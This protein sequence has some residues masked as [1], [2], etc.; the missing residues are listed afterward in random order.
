MTPSP[1]LATANLA[2]LEP[3]SHLCAFYDTD[4]QLARIASTFVAWGLAAGDQML[5]VAGDGDAA[6][7]MLTSL[8]DHLPGS[9]ALASGQLMVRTFEDT[10]GG[11]H[12]GY[13]VRI[14]AGFRAAA[15]ES[16][17]SGYPALRVAAEMGDVATFLGSSDEVLRW[18]RRATAMQRDLGVSS[19]CQYDL[20]HIEKGHAASLAAEHTALA[21]DGDESPMATFLAVGDPWGLRVA[22][23]VDIANRAGLIRAIRSRAAVS[24]RVHL[25]LHGLTFADVGTL[26][27]LHALAAA[28]PHDG[29]LV[30]RR[31][32]DLLRRILDI[33]GLRHQRLVVEA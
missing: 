5:Y 12:D 9:H 2:D 32:P 24:P 16:R 22:G 23:E 26:S 7:T 6:T 33:T 19:V 11:T 30:L 10:Y 3:G 17:K 1:E 28:L 4:Q 8:L 27:G 20:R 31:P 29:H 18:E 13:L 15:E 21:P 25:D 14:E